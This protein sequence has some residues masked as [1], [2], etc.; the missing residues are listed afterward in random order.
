MSPAPTPVYDKDAYYRRRYEDI[1]KTYPDANAPAWEDL[2]EEQKTGV[3]TEVDRYAK[4]M[5][6]FGE[7]IAAG[8][9]PEPYR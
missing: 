5:Q 4:H 7:D 8:R 2:T 1:R 3:R 9:M 6:K